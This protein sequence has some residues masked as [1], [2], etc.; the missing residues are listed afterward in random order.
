MACH[1]YT[2]LHSWFYELSS[3]MYH[4]TSLLRNNFS[5]I[6][7][8]RENAFISIMR[9][10]FETCCTAGSGTNLY[11]DPGHMEAEKLELPQPQNT[12]CS[13]KRNHTPPILKVFFFFLSCIQ[14]Q[15]NCR[16]FENS[17]RVL[18]CYI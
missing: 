9:I 16:T 3:L 7:I 11:R 1:Y 14:Y 10:I 8:K 13:S 12:L 5:N 2:L 17:A 15:H 4:L 18:Q 6:N